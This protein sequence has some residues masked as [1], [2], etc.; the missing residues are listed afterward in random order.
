MF[1]MPQEAA[2]LEIRTHDPVVQV[3]HIFQDGA[4][5][6]FGIRVGLRL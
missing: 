6:V 5:P 1:P 4:D 3:R 2:E